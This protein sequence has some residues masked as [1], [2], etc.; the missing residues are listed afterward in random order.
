MRDAILFL[1]RATA[2]FAVMIVLLRFFLQYFRA[3]F[4]N[5][6]A[7][8]ILQLTSPLIVPLRRILPPIGKIDTATIVVALALELLV[9]ALLGLMFFGGL[10]APGTLIYVGIVRTLLLGFQLLT[11]IVFIYV[12]LSW[13]SP[14]A[15]N[16]IIA[17][18]GAIA[19]PLLRPVRRFMPPL[20]GLDLSPMVAILL[21]MAIN[22]FLRQQ[23]PFGYH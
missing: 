11:F 18:I 21:L 19:D 10:L 6:V 3:G 12:I 23:L 14:G 9:I 2:D 5:P 13:I 17:M 15:Y 4:Q 20:G 7:Q 8:A 22:I 16:P 1:F